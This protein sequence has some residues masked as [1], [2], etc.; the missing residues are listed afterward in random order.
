MDRGKGQHTFRGQGEVNPQRV[1]VVGVM[2]LL[3]LAHPADPKPGALFI[4]HAHDA[5]DGTHK[6][7]EAHVA[8][9]SDQEG[10]FGIDLV[11]ADADQD[12]VER[13]DGYRRGV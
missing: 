1:G 9:R 4:A 8:E 5:G 10:D 11:D 6:L 3:V 7:F 13:H 2:W 12:V